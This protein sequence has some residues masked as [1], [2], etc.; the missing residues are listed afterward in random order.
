MVEKITRIF[1]VLIFSKK[2]ILHCYISYI[3]N[4]LSDL[5]F[6]LQAIIFTEKTIA[7]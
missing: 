3:L 6:L 4:K 1:I 5:G 2:L 7:G